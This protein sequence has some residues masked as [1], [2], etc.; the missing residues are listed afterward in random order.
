M[1]GRRALLLVLPVCLACLVPLAACLRL[2]GQSSSTA[3]VAVRS[4]TEEQLPCVVQ[5]AGTEKIPACSP[6]TAASH[7]AK[8]QQRWPIVLD[9]QPLPSAEEPL[10]EGVLV[11]DKSDVPP[12][13]SL[14]VPVF[15][16]DHDRLKQNLDS[17]FRN[18]C[19]SYEVVITIDHYRDDT[20]Q[21]VWNAVERFI[22]TD[23]PKMAQRASACGIHPDGCET[24]CGSRLLRVVVYKS[25]KDMFET[26]CDNFA[27]SQMSPHGFYLL[28]QSDGLFHEPG[29]NVHMSLA[30]RAHEKILAVSGRCGH[31]FVECGD[32]N[33]GYAGDCIG[34]KR[35]KPEELEASQ[36]IFTPTD[37]VVRS[38]MLLRAKY[39]QELGFFDQVHY[40]LGDDDKDLC[41]RGLHE[42]GW[43]SGV[44]PIDIYQN[45]FSETIDEQWKKTFDHADFKTF[46]EEWSARRNEIPELE[47]SRRKKDHCVKDGHGMAGAV[48]SQKLGGLFSKF[49]PEQQTLSFG[50]GR[51]SAL[52]EEA[53]H[54]DLRRFTDD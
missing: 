6:T 21:T 41:R 52:I 20:V 24:P 34:A 9:P 22:A 47:N 2:K 3:A 10:L 13:Y 14:S 28:V 16:V 30:P 50:S 48:V 8:L 32:V 45:K 27:M 46:Q 40:K 4:S 12:E 44:V 49:L 38:P 54:A 43:I 39:V 5:R 42:G 33:N 26:A 31:S 7:L 29:W 53:N 11:A 18:T 1:V 36:F 15:T 37:I 35:R 17:L 19:G 23:Y 51:L 25:A